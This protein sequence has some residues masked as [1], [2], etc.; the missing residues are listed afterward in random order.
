LSW[1]NLGLR[2]FVL[3]IVVGGVQLKLTDV[4]VNDPFRIAVSPS[5]INL[6]GPAFAKGFL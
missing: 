2:I 4:P 3:F 6:S 1:I 5:I